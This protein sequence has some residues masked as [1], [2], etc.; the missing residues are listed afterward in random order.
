MKRIIVIYKT[1]K[2]INNFKP[3][4]YRH[5]LIYKSKKFEIINDSKS[6]TLSSTT[7]FLEINEKMIYHHCTIM[8]ISCRCHVSIILLS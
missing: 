8:F 5:Q 6:T 2:T 3:L 4:K 7:P 1:V